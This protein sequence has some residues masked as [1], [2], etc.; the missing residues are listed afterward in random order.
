MDERN[1]LQD[2]IKP[3]SLHESKREW[4]VGLFGASMSY[5]LILWLL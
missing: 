4:W 1:L 5:G 2:A 3:L